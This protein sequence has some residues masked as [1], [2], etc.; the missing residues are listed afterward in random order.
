MIFFCL[1]V[2]LILIAL[3]VF[4]YAAYSFLVTLTNTAAG[5][6]EVIWPGEPIQDWLFKIWYL[7]WLLA[8]WAVPVSLLLSIVN[9]PKPLFALCL[10]SFLWLLF[11]IGLLSSL[12]GASR[13]I[14]LRPAIVGLLLKHFGTTLA[15]YA[16]SGFVVLICGTLAYTAV[17]GLPIARGLNQPVLLL[18]LAA[19]FAA[20][21]WLIYARLLGRFAFII[22]QSGS[23]RRKERRHELSKEL[24]KQKKR[25]PKKPYRAYDPWTAPP[26]EPVR[27]PAQ[28]TSSTPSRP[29]DPYGPA[30]GTYEM[31]ADGTIPSP[32]EASDNDPTQ[33]EEEVRPY[34]ASSLEA[35]TAHKLPAPTLPEVSK[36]EEELAAPRRLPS[37][38]PMP[39]VIGVY[40]FP[41]Y[42]QTIGPC[43]TLALG[44][45][46]VMGLSRL[47]LYLVD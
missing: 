5:T 7:A 1:F 21:G 4:S 43:G 29:E 46:G 28:S 18:P 24:P 9:V 47:L 39:L 14:V 36:L 35:T 23:G 20:A 41:F 37:L 17:F 25:R 16:S 22:S 15:F 6:D 27:K 2:G 45:F 31:M 3:L 26:D 42:Q 8:I 33:D 10:A 44:Y 13:L 38:P 40:S 34:A 19:V 12:S 30:E 11:P 32:V